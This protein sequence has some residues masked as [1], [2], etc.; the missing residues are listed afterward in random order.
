M[1]FLPGLEKCLSV[2]RRGEKKTNT[3]NPKCIPYKK[4]QA[5]PLT[6]KACITTPR[7]RGPGAHPFPWVSSTEMP[8]VPAKHELM[9]WLNLAFSIRKSPALGNL[10]S[11]RQSGMPASWLSRMG[12]RELIA[13]WSLGM[14]L[15]GIPAQ[16][17][18]SLEGESRALVNNHHQ[19]P[20]EHICGCQG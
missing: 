8:F 19:R 14:V 12:Q 11:Q 15:L 1:K 18:C 4:R 2:K 16:G 3:Q 10:D 7:T 6:A 17:L 13:D 5:L 9:Y 20:R